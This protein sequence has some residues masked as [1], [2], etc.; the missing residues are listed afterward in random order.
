M[1]GY[2][3][4]RDVS[5]VTNIYRMFRSATSFSTKNYDN[6]LTG[7]ANKILQ[8]NVLFE[9]LSASY[10]NGETARASILNT[11]GLTISDAGKR[12]TNMLKKKG[13]N[14]TGLLVQGA[15]IKMIMEEANKLNA[16]LIIAGHNQHDFIYKAFFASVLEKI[17]KK[18]KRPV[19]I[20]L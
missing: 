7:G 18:A 9:A 12:Y 8:P 5:N 6:L 11:Y 4:N 17:V 16:N 15:T 19:L 3:G 20:V 2:I 14:A 13:V 10:C 1:L